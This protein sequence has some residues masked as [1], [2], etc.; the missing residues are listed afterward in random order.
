MR[1]VFWVLYSL[2]L[3]AVA[4]FGIG[5]FGLL[6]PKRL[7]VAYRWTWER[8]AQLARSPAILDETEA[9]YVG[10]MFVLGAIILAGAAALTI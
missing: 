9:R 4:A 1:D 5:M 2:N 3:A 7:L 6:Q 10:L 8:S